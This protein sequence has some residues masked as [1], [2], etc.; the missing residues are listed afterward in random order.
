MTRVFLA[1][2]GLLT[3]GNWVDAQSSV[4]PQTPV[5]VGKTATEADRQVLEALLLSL[6]TDTEFPV[7]AKP[8]RP[9]MVLHRRTPKMISAVVNTAQVMYETDR[10][11]L[12]KDAWD[13]LVRRNEVRLDP[14]T[15]E[16][17]YEGLGFDSRITVGNAFPGPEAPFIGKSFEEVFPEARGWVEA[18]VPGFS[19]DRRT[20]VIRARVGPTEK[21]AML[22]AIMKQDRGK[23]VVLWRRYCLYN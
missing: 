15:R 11:V 4:S 14:R 6:A 23:W 20:A 22:T 18:W 2:F 8:E 19:K 12:P 10:R 17:H 7:P 13:D 9:N 1:I 16:V 3:V 5:T 21:P